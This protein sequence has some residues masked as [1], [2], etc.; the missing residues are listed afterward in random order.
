MN[1]QAN[2]DIY[3]SLKDY[4][5]EYAIINRFNLRYMHQR[6]LCSKL[7]SYFITLLKR[8]IEDHNKVMK[9]LD[10]LYNK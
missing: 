4:G 2:M 7:D 1:A 9:E 10:K 5:L 6:H 8:H 3:L